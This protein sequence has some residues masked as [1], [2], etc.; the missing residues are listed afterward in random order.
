M[1]LLGRKVS[2]GTISRWLKQAEEWIGAGNVLPDFSDAHAS[3]PTPMD[4]ERID[5]G[6]RQD[7]RARHQ[8]GR[9]NSD[10]DD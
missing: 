5:L 9:R 6:E 4:P 2:Q 8:R 10:R 3:K 1:E 7:G